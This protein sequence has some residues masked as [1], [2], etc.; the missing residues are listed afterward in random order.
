[1][2][3]L[4]VAGSSFRARRLLG[5]EGG[6]VPRPVAI[7]MREDA[8]G[9][10]RALATPVTR[11]VKTSGEIRGTIGVTFTAFISEVPAALRGLWAAAARFVCGASDA[12]TVLTATRAPG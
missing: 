3:Q 2:L 4:T 8:V 12:G 9:R 7:R 6:T 5:T 1:V 10:S 11:K